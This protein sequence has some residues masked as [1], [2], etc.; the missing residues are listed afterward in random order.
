MTRDLTHCQIAMLA[1]RVSDT[2][3]CVWHQSLYQQ[4]SETDEHNGQRDM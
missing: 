2:E 1:T 4:L 3:Q